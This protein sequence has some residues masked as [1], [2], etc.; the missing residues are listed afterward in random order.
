M[1]A[2]LASRLGC[3]RRSGALLKGARKAMIFFT[4]IGIDVIEKAETAL[5]ETCQGLLLISFN[6]YLIRRGV[7][8][9]YAG[10]EYNE[11][12]PFIEEAGTLVTQNLLMQRQ[13]K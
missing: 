7:E 4:W 8:E 5:S 1:P 11:L 12:E 9:L 6:D 2:N 13:S 10:R 3:V